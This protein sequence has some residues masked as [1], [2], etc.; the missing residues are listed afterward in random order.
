MASEILKRDENHEPVIGMVTDDSNQFI[1]M[2]RIDDTTKGLKVMLVGGA[3]TGTVTSISQSTGILLTPN[4]ITTTGT[5]A[6]STPLQPITTLT[7][8]SLKFLRVNAGETAIEYANPTDT[9]IT[10]LTGNVTAGPG[11][12]SQVATIAN[13]AVTY[14]KMQ[15]IS[16]TGLLLG[17]SSTTTAVQEITVGSGL[18]LS[19]T[20]LS[21]TGSGGTVTTVSVVTANGFAGSVA[22]ATTTPAITLTTSINSP[23]LAGNGTAISAATTT[24]TGSTVVLQGSPTITTASLGSSTATTQTFGTNDTTLATTAFVQ[25]ATLGQNFKEACRVA[26]TANLVGVY[27][28][29]ASG[30]GATF[31][32]TA[33]GTDIID[34]VT[35]VLGDRVLVK[36]QTTDFQNGIYTVTTAGAIGIAGVLTRATDANQSGEFKTGDSTFITAGTTQ[37]TTTWAYTGIDSP[38]IGTTSLTFVQTAGQGSFTAGNGITITGTSIAID[39][40]VTVDKTTVQTLTN[41]TLTSPTFTAPVLGTPT[42]GVMTNVTGTAANLTSGIT[43]ALASAT[44][45]VNVSSATAPTSGQ[46][47][48]ATGGTAATWQT[49]STTGTPAWVDEGTLTWSAEN[50]DKTLTF[51]NSGKDIYMGILFFSSGNNAAI[52]M[53]LNGVTATN[54]TTTK[55]SDSTVTTTGGAASFSVTTNATSAMA[56]FYITGKHTSGGK[57]ITGTASNIAGGT[58]A[59]RLMDGQLTGDSNNLSNLT[60]LIGGTTVSAK[61]HM[62]SL[63]L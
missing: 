34:G 30:V 49:P 35:L 39:T 7:G 31:T 15:A 6:L 5:V 20:T 10:Q 40:S 3:G 33:T 62:Y 18:S 19:G 43:Q 54:Y 44:T 23:V 25:A 12:G 11:S 17:S 8:N 9:G 41:K 37:S 58:G 36:N 38:T 56:T 16:S 52:T 48:T 42:S 45:T 60:I 50:T 14:A 59:A 32:Y 21:S 46:V 29:G 1:K 2:G 13:N 27:L 61:L 26:T 53:Q 28:N 24:G 22:N 63:N 4:P 47:L 51:N 55:H 57:T